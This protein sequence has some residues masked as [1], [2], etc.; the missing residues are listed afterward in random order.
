LEKWGIPDYDELVLVTSQ[1]TM[2]K[3]QAVML[4]IR[5]IVDQA[6]QWVRANPEEALEHY[7]KEVPEADRRIEREAFQLTLPYYAHRQAPDVNQ[8]Q[9]F[10]DFALKYGLIEKAVDVRSIIWSN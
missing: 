4:K 1:K 10:A 8:W 2:K 3:N 9:Q 5:R 6:I 7:F